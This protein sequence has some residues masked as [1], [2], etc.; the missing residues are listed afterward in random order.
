V[1]EASNEWPI[2]AERCFHALDH[3]RVRFRDVTGKCAI[4]VAPAVAVGVGV[5]I[6]A[7]AELAVEAVVVIGSVA[8]AAAIVAEIEA[9]RA[10]KGCTCFCATKNLFL[11][12]G[13][14]KVQDKAAC[15]RYCSATYPQIDPVAVC[16]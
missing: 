7:A 15:Q 12:D 1:K 2:L 11:G 5:C 3:D 14:V 4:A 13:T 9:A 16:K 6:L 8:A 10:R